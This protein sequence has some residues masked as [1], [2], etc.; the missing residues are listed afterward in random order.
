MTGYLL[1]LKAP[2]EQNCL[3]CSQA[4][5]HCQTCTV[6][7]AC[8]TCEAGYYVLTDTGQCDLCINKM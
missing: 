4:I 6:L 3:N 5:P 2:D 8:V 7:T 1:N